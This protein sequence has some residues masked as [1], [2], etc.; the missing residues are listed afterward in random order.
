MA[1]NNDTASV[2]A[3]EKKLVPSDGYLFGCQW[4]TKEQA[5]PLTLQEKSVRGT[6]SNRFNKKDAGDFTKIQ[7]NS[8][9]KL[10]VQTC[11][12]WMPVCVGQDQ[13]YVEATFHTQSIRG[14]AQP[15]ACNNAL[16]KQSYSAAVSAVHYQ[17]WLFRIGETLCDQPCQCPF[18]IAQPRW[19]RRD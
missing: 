17:I 1:K 4:E 6:I 5:T 3:F 9:Q 7:L 15:S 2:L 11:S 8:M 13:R 12:E 19:R 18:S 14:L 10:K 16:F